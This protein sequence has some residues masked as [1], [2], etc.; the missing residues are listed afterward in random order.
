MVVERSV[1]TATTPG[2]QGLTGGHDVVLVAGLV[3]P[4]EVLS[5][6]YNYLV[7]LSFLYHPLAPPSIILCILACLVHR[8]LL[9]GW[10]GRCRRLR[11]FSYF[12]ILSTNT[13]N[14]TQVP[15]HPYLNIP[16]I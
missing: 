7:T 15:T 9:N 11:V 8:A 3:E 6:Y 10:A 2:R 1:V 16:S 12:C 14:V 13:R 5:Y 4:S